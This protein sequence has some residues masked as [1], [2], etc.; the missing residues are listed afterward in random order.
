MEHDTCIQDQKLEVYNSIRNEFNAAHSKLVEFASGLTGFTV[1][2]KRGKL[3]VVLAEVLGAKETI[4]TVRNVES[5]A[6]YF[7]DISKSEVL[8]IGSI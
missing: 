8:K 5:D 2:F 6:V 7:I 1:L 3:Q 4:L